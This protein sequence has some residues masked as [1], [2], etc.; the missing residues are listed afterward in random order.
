LALDVSA[1][2]SPVPY[3]PSIELVDIQSLSS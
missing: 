1:D 3:S 2:S